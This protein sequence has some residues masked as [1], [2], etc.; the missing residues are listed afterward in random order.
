MTIEQL[1]DSIN[2]LML[3]T[4]YTQ[5][6]LNAYFSSNDYVEYKT[7]DEN[8]NEI[9]VPVKSNEKYKQEISDYVVRSFTNTIENRLTVNTG[10]LETQV[11]FGKSF[12]VIM[13]TDGGGSIVRTDDTMV[14]HSGEI[15]GCRE[16]VTNYYK[17]KY[18]DKELH[19]ITSE[20]TLITADSNIVLMPNLQESENRDGDKALEISVDNINALNQSLDIKS[21]TVGSKEN[22]EAGITAKLFVNELNLTTK[23]EDGNLIRGFMNLYDS[24]DAMEL[25]IF[26][27]DR[28]L[29]SKQ[30]TFYNNKDRDI[31][32]GGYSPLT[33]AAKIIHV[34]AENGDDSH[35]GTIERPIKTFT[36]ARQLSYRNARVY[37]YLK[38]GQTF[39]YDTNL[40]MST[41][42]LLDIR[43]WGDNDDIDNPKL[44]PNSYVKTID[45]ADYTAVNFI[46]MYTG[47]LVIRDVE[48]IAP[49]KIDDHDFHT[50]DYSGNLINMQTNFGC[51]RL[52]VN[53]DGKTNLSLVSSM[54]YNQTINLSLYKIYA[55]LGDEQL[56]NNRSHTPINLYVTN[57]DIDC[58][59]D[60][61][62]QLVR[63][64][65]RDSDTG[66]PLNVSCNISL[67]K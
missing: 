9:T 7:L 38:E 59:N 18:P 53:L 35:Y 49:D 8:G 3:N 23:D 62:D 67:V 24:G 52:T 10:A 13:I 27:K 55:T 64:V 29:L 16:V 58:N 47:L 14:L 6:F 36:R 43:R 30:L 48:I 56:I 50:F 28:N 20:R 32:V 44:K 60:I 25:G 66:I 33:T 51:H 34:D 21:I 19:E 12:D 57:N 46:V 11:R 5:S 4:K 15:A 17:L 42:S 39:E 54:R 22:R 40:D 2:R 41:L 31:L 65:L 61:K 1:N 37:I 63:Y 45:D 26:D